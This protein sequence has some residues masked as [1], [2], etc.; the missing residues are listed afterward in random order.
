MGLV[1]A[2]ALTGDLAGAR[3]G[4]GDALALAEELDDPAVIAG[5]I[6]GFDVPAI[7]TDND[8]PSLADRIVRLTE[9]TLATLPADKTAERSRLLATLA[10]ELRNTAGERGR[11]AAY[12]AETTARALN[13]PAL[14]AFALNA[15]FMQSFERAGLAPQR[16]AIGAE[17][18][19]S[20]RHGTSW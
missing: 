18:A 20:W 10:L 17:M 5:V 4:R 11:A 2:L 9:R 15:R 7:W 8:D 6:A 12:E 1:R 13:D 19:L 3:Q 14:L 16:D